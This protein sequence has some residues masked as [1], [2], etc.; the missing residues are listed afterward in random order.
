MTNFFYRVLVIL[1]MR[2]DMFTARK[3]KGRL[4]VPEELSLASFTGTAY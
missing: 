3:V 4:A 2:F 1:V